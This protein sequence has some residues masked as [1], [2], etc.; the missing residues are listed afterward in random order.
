MDNIRG[1]WQEAAEYL[2][3]KMNAL[4]YN[5]WIANLVPA[6]VENNRLYLIAESELAKKT[7]T[8]LYTEA[9]TEALN[10]VSD[11]ELS[12]AFITENESI[13][14]TPTNN[15]NPPPMLNPKYT[16]DTF[17]VG[18][19]NKFAHAACTA[20]A[21]K[22]AMAYNPLFIYGGVGLGKT[23]LMHAIGHAIYEANPN[24]KVMYV[25]C[26][27]FTNELIQSVRDNSNAEFRKKYRDI[28]V[29]M[30]DD[31]QF[32]Q[33][34]V[35]T[36]S[37]FFHTFNTLFVADKQIVLTSD[38][39]PKEIPTLDAR[40]YSRFECGLVADINAP[41]FETRAAILRKRADMDNIQISNEVINY[42][43]EKIQSNIREL[44]GAFTRV[45]AYSQLS[46]ERIT[47]TLVD[48]VLTDLL[49]R[50]VS[51]RITPE[52]IIQAVSDYYQYS[53]EDITGK[54]RD[55]RVSTARQLCMYLCRRILDL[56][57]EDIGTVLGG[58]H[59]TTVMY[60]CEKIAEELERSSRG[61]LKV[62][63]ED[64]EARLQ[65]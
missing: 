36:Q 24:A 49:Q 64:I 2:K 38:R 12:V 60:A 48:K 45:V 22:P 30:V 59:Y 29:L 61:E 47:N 25:T 31:V 46:G 57:Y 44:E 7:L 54:K 55:K 51:R 41:D 16:F 28:D 52:I 32:L 3:P 26:E 27:A 13:P 4:S 35:S 42:I 43:A 39:P 58:K 53:T 63:I 18:E 10:T 56:S 33:G 62:A 17:V 9:I 65:L 15:G 21:K 34:K 1:L 5:N 37:E 40:M 6:R 14:E 20:V 23:H 50:S 19:S 11:R 8:N